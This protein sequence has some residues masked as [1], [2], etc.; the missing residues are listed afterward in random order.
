MAFFLHCSHFIF[1]SGK[2]KN[3][4]WIF[5]MLRFLFLIFFFSTTVFAGE[6]IGARSFALKSYIAVSNDVWT[7]FYNPAGISNL[8]D[9]EISIS[10]IPAQFEIPELSKKAIAYFEPSLPVKFGAGVQ[11]FGFSLYKETAFKLSIAKNFNLFDIG[12]NLNYNLVSI[13][14]YGSAGAFSVDL[15]FLSNPLKFL[16]FGFALKNM[17]ATKLGQAREGLPKEFDFGVAILPYENLLISAQVDKEIYFKESFKYGVE[18]AV[19]NFLFIRVGF[20]NYPVQ[21]SGGFGLN[22][23]LFQVD[24]SINQHQSLGLTHQFTFSA[25]LGKGE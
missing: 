14:N 8:K 6:N 22:I 21:Y 5:M 16:K 1:S 13:K 23:F 12:V 9:R 18:Y 7:I 11:I 25:K 17:V 10:Y 4:F 19:E 24:Y 20:M 15:G 3:H 2:F